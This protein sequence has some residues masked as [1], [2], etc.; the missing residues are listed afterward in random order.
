VADQVALETFSAAMT[1][2][3][4]ERTDGA[5]QIRPTGEAPFHLPE[6]PEALP[7]KK[8]GDVETEPEAGSQ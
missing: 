5:A 4:M 3:D 6:L 1:M 2:S 8:A 7:Q